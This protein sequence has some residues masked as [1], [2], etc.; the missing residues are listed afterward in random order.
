ML[1]DANGLLS[2]AMRTSCLL[3]PVFTALT[4][5]SPGS[6]VAVALAV[7]FA[8]DRGVRLGVAAWRLGVRA[9]AGAHSFS[10]PSRIRPGVLTRHSSRDSVLF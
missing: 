5:D 3:V 2:A 6:V 9:D 1:G 8:P 4:A 10:S 7:R